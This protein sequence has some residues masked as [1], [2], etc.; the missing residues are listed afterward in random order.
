MVLT[1]TKNVIELRDQGYT[2]LKDV[3]DPELDIQPVIDENISVLKKLIN[4]L[5]S[6][7]KISN[8]YDGSD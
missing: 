1:Q 5:I 6:Q 8:T 2:V 7:G 3:L 4:K